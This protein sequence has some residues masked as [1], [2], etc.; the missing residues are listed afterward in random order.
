[1]C[2][3]CIPAMPILAGALCGGGL[4]L[5]LRGMLGSL[6]AKIR[7]VERLSVPSKEKKS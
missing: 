6:L 4:T 5:G 3:S 1:M 7:A 2:P